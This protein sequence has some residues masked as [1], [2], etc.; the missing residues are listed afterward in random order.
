[1]LRPVD[2]GIRERRRLDGLW[3]FRAD[4]G[5]RGWGEEWWHRPLTG[6]L[7][8]PVPSS[9]NDVYPDARLHDHVG[10]TWYQTSVAVPPGWRGRRI[11][12]RFDAATHAAT[13]WVGDAE[14]ARHQGGYTPFEADITARVAP[15]ETF[16]VTV[17]VNNELS[18]ATIPPGEVEVRPDGRRVQRWFHDF[19]NYAGLHRSVWLCTTPFDRISDIAVTTALD[20]AHGEVA[21]RVD[22]EGEGS[23]DVD[24]LDAGGLPVASGTERAGSLRVDP[25]HP[26]A[27]GDGYLYTLR[28]R[29]HG[30]GG[31]EDR[32]DLPVGIRTVAVDGGRFLVNGR[33]FRFRGFGRH[34]DAEVRGRGHDDALMVRDFALMDWLGAN[35]FRT[36]HYPYAEEVMEYADR[37]GIAVI[38]ETPA[39]GLHLGLGTG[40]GVPRRPTFGTGAVDGTT[41]AAHLQA[42]RELIARDRNHPCVLMW[43]LAN[44]PDAA[45]PAARDY[46]LPL[47]A[48][49]R[50]LD[51][52]RPLCFA[53]AHDPA[54]VG[55][56]AISDLF[57]VICLNRYFGWYLDVGDL[58]LAERHLEADL[59]AW[60][61]SYA[62]P[63]VVTEYGADAVAGLRSV[64]PAPWTEEYQ[65]DLLAMCHRVFDRVEAVVGEHV[66][67][68]ADFATAAGLHR[69]EGNRK[70][71]FT[72]DRKPKLAAH[73]LR[74]RWKARAPAGS[75]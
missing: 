45:D 63:I 13:V 59:R 36:S 38:D 60:A 53:S 51:P 65:R 67:N 55:H 9:Y 17:C 40:R 64:V 46:F 26:W 54:S 50:R 62:K 66:W 33:P 44:E 69:V 1:M 25:V 7:E 56:D 20:G 23:L 35:S 74:E 6:P 21:Y 70:G 61:A 19:F 41:R 18:W 57:D 52:T 8:M 24:L 71:V 42:V 48:E 37:H 27:P 43:S 28:V 16:R 3:R 68:F 39:V 14:V 15:D 30:G 12:L 29:L 5:G 32:Y 49:A 73:L 72:R 2:N 22:V 4:P 75:G 34:E 11:A 10:D 58:D 47:V 31:E